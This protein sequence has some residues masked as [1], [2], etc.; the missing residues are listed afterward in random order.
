MDKQ[1]I[2][3]NKVIFLAV[4][5]VL[6]LS[7]NGFSQI[8][9]TKF[10]GSKVAI[11]IPTRLK[12]AYLFDYQQQDAEQ[13]KISINPDTLNIRNN[14]E[15]ILLGLVKP[16]FGND[17][18]KRYLEFQQKLTFIYQGKPTAIISYFVKKDSIRL[19]A[20]NNL[21]Q[22][23][24]DKWNIVKIQAIDDI[25]EVC[26]SVKNEAFWKIYSSKISEDKDIRDIQEKVQNEQKITN[27]S[28]VYE[29]IR[30]LKKQK[31]VS[32]LRKILP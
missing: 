15:G 28:K 8:D 3:K 30:E 2:M 5:L 21:L 11:T 4:L 26:S 27:I 9:Y 19:S 7:K 10:K 32:I 17:T 18:V 31:K 20:Q 16:N 1:K 14:P 24:D 6:L 22:F 12:D 29:I 23:Y 25:Y 13:L